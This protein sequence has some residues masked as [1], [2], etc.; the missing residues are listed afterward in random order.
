M[1][2]CVCVIC[3]R[4]RLVYVGIYAC[5]Y[6]WLVRAFA[7]TFVS[8]NFFSHSIRFRSRNYFASNLLLNSPK[9]FHVEMLLKQDICM[10]FLAGI[11]STYL[12]W[13]YRV[14]DESKISQL[15][16]W[17]GYTVHALIFRLYLS[18]L[19]YGLNSYYNLILIILYNGEVL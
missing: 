2:V 1:L 11:Y 15:C 12:Y 3:N 17:T 8:G 19:K 13:I 5:R 4:S 14:A 18:A 10:N 7:I 9:S 16:F 6:V